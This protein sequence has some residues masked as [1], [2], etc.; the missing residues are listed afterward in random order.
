MSNDIFKTA[1]AEMKVNDFEKLAEEKSSFDNSVFLVPAE[2][3]NVPTI[4]NIDVSKPEPSKK[5]YGMPDKGW[6]NLPLEDLPSSGIF[7]PKGAQLTI[8]SAQTKEIRHF[9]T[10]DERDF[11]NVDDKLNSI[12]ESCSRFTIPGK[13]NTNFKDLLEFDRLYIILAIRELTFVQNEGNLTMNIECS[14]CGNADRVEITKESIGKLNIDE[15]LLKY[16]EPNTN[17]FNIETKSGEKFQLHLP[18][19]GITSFVK[20]YTRIRS[21]QNQFIDETFLRL[22]LYTIADHK[23]LND[24]TFKDYNIETNQWSRDKISIIP[25]LIGLIDNA[26]I[27]SITHQCSS[28][29]VEDTHPISF[30]EGIK[31]LFLLTDVFDHLV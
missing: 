6:K 5:I 18:T 7:Y 17:N 20:N 15:R 10:I 11:L 25:T 22:A 31:G 30:Q 12:V 4:K 8:R 19:L 9:S 29:G 16:Q 28:C 21:Y 24:K 13:P 1:I 3:E 14:N 27:P 23:T 26:I 2:Q